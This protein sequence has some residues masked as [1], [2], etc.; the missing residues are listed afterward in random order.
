MI[1]DDLIINV[2]ELF[3][4]KK[5]PVA[6]IGAMAVNAYNISRFTKDVD[7]M[8]LI[9][10]FEGILPDLMEMGLE[11]FHKQENFVRL[12]HREF[13][14]I[15][16]DFLFVDE[17]TLQH[18]LRDG[19]SIQMFKQTFVVPS[20]NHLIAMKLHAIKQNPEREIKDLLDIANLIKEHN[21][22]VLS[23]SFRALCL[24]YGPDTTY[25]KLLNIF[26]T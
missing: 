15:I 23:E 16:T 19:K 9:S 10:D 1:L 26:K 25:D 5:I 22:S 17:G 6:L 21:V 4:K 20:L 13:R 8:I 7:F 11:I 18:I 12:R 3:K 14:E 24:K 2:G